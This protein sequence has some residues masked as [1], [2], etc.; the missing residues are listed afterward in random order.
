VTSKRDRFVTKAH[1]CTQLPRE[2]DR[3]FPTFG[4]DVILLVDDEDCVRDMLRQH[5]A[6]LPYIVLEARSGSEALEIA[7][8]YPGKVP[9]LV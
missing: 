7:E 3:I 8:R 6:R 1:L 5:L 2:M 4:R 9:L